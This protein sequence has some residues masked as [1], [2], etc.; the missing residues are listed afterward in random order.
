MIVGS[1][2]LMEQSLAPMLPLPPHISQTSVRLYRQGFSNRRR[3]ERQ[4]E[5]YVLSRIMNQE[6][7]VVREHAKTMRDFH[8]AKR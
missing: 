2:K 6:D 8:Q 7:Y 4:E 3:F 1:N 5:A